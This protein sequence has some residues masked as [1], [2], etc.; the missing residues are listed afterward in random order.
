MKS[1]MAVTCSSSSIRLTCAAAATASHFPESHLTRL[2]SPITASSSSRHSLHPHG[3]P[4]C[5]SHPLL[6]ARRSSRA[7]DLGP[8]PRTT[9][10]ECMSLIVSFA[11][12]NRTRVL[13]LASIRSHHVCATGARRHL[14]L[15]GS[16]DDIALTRNWC[17][18]EPLD[19]ACRIL[20]DYIAAFT[21]PSRE[22]VTRGSIVI[23]S[24]WITRISLKLVALQ[25]I[26]P[27]VFLAKHHVFWGSW[28]APFISIF[29][30][31][32][33]GCFP[34]PWNYCPLFGLRFTIE[35]TLLT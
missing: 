21:T 2:R 14:V 6:R 18:W 8:S 5:A 17:H 19:R 28:T 34:F 27:V 30:S 22:D 31:P 15:E 29:F 23:R 1:P 12:V 4:R 11:L 26:K 16:R 32:L 10:N 3:Q 13:F 25:D 24:S 7:S 20:Y 35:G 9:E 33:R